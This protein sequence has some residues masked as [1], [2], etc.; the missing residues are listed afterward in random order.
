MKARVNELVANFANY[1]EIFDQ[2]ELFTGPSLYFHFKT[3]NLRRQYRSVSEAIND[4]KFLDCI[5]ATLASWG[6]HRMGQGNTKL[7]EFRELTESFRNQTEQIQEIESRRIL[8]IELQHIDEV[9]QHLWSVISRLKVGIGKTKIVSGSKALHHLLPDLV[10]PIDRE[11]TIRFFYNH[12]TLNRGDEK[13]F[14]EMY[15]RFHHIA[16]SCRAEIKS[17]IGRGMNTSITKVIDNA[18]VGYC[19]EH[20]KKNKAKR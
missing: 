8:E 10:P 4:D 20:L 16:I 11:Y 7:A 1:C 2:A 15:P 17:R 9:A 3:M 13:P 12:T 18:I 14:K 19:L 6:L 5:Y